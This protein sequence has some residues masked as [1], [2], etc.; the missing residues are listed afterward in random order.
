VAR[1]T[2]FQSKELLR[3][4]GILTPKGEVG[5][6]PEAC[7]EIAARLGATVV[8]KAQIGTTNRAKIGAVRVVTGAREAS[9]A[10]REMFEATGTAQILVEERIKVTAEYYVGIVMDDRERCPVLLASASGGSG[11]E[12]RESTIHRISLDVLADVSPKQFLAFAIAAGLPE[13]AC[14]VLEELW[15][16]ARRSDAR[17]AEINP[18]ARSENGQLIALDCRISIDDYSV[19]RHPEFGIDFA[20]ETAEPPT[21]LDHIAWKL[22][23]DDYRGTFFFLQLPRQHEGWPLI[24]FHGC[25]GGGAIAAQDALSCAE[26]EAADFVDTSGNPPASKV[27]RATRIILSQPGITGYFLCGSGMASQDQADL[28][29]A[30]VKAFREENLEIPAVLR[31]GGN[32]E[33]RAALIMQRYAAEAGAAIETYQKEHSTAFCVS[34]LR[35]LIEAN[36]RTPHRPNLGSA[37]E[38]RAHPPAA[39]SFETRTGQIH[40]DHALCILCE[41]KA[42]IAACQPDILKLVGDLPELAISAADAKRGRCT[43]CLACEEECWNQG[44]HG[45]AIDFPIAGLLAYRKEHASSS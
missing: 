18:L 37:G 7:G 39:Y 44:N 30:L 8:V 15:R 9:T 36:K 22:E 31:L 14:F 6:T 33:E 5:A 23:S 12:E 17:S 43:E 25:G 34:R 4:S 32:G 41:S 19:F 13:D 3:S 20:R 24:G 45:A 21:E 27:Y 26:L 40:Y 35:H 42:C 29:R 11:I 28:A 10:A 16:L 38:M 2:E 1:L